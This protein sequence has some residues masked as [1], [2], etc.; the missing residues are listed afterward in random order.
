MVEWRTCRF[1]VLRLIILPMAFSPQSLLARITREQ[2]AF[3][4]R[5]WKEPIEAF[6]GPTAEREEILGERRRWLAEHPE[7]HLVYRQDAAPLI[8]EAAALAQGIEPAFIP[9]TDDGSPRQMLGELGVHWEADLVLLA[10]DQDGQIRM[11]AGVVC[12]PSHWA[13]ESK[14]GLPI[15]AVHAPVPGLNQAIGPQ[16][17][18]LLDRLPAGYAWQRLNWGLNASAERNQ[19]PQRALPWL[20]PDTP[21]G[22]IYLRLEYQALVRLSA[23]G[24]ILFGIRLYNFDLETVRAYP[25]AAGALARQLRSMPVEMQVYKGIQEVAC[26]V[27]DYLQP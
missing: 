6:F 25:A 22:D 3:D 24:G 17:Y 16:I 2:F 12:F 15:E 9:G 20:T 11:Q 26:R 1:V 18:K 14:L 5:G 4:L 21:P 27:A 23:T 7:R 13:P 8:G 10:K 19:H